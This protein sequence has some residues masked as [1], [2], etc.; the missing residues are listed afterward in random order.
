MH[1]RSHA[2]FFFCTRDSRSDK[3]QVFVLQHFCTRHLKNNFHFARMSRSAD[4]L[5]FHTRYI[6]RAR[7]LPIHYCSHSSFTSTTPPLFGRFVE[8]HRLTD[9][10]FNTP[11]EVRSEA[12]SVILSPRRSSLEPTYDVLGKKKTDLRRLTSSLF[13]Q[14]RKTS[15]NP[16]WIYHPNKET[17]WIWSLMHSV[18]N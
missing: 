13:L 18:F 5:L 10:E 3:T 8:Q 15:T 2:S 12:R 14:E 1:T 6:L 4:H 17:T 7:R 9:Y 16:F 11:I